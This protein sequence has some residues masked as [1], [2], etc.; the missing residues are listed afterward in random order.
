MHKT[1]LGDALAAATLAAAGCV[2]DSAEATNKKMAASKVYIGALT[3]DIA[4]GKDYLIAGSREARCVYSP[5]RGEHETYKATVRRL[6][7]GTHPDSGLAK[8]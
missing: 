2:Q 6:Q 7:H 4:G 8:T 5:L 1:V 3:C